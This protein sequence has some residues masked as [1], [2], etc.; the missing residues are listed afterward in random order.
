MSRS[1]K[2]WRRE[3]G[4]HHSAQKPNSPVQRDLMEIDFQW[5]LGSKTRQPNTKSVTL[6]PNQQLTII[7]TD[8][9]EKKMVNLKHN[10]GIQANEPFKNIFVR[11][12]R[13]ECLDQIV[14]VNRVSF[15]GELRHC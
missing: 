12:Q 4:N 8:G 6:S 11:M 14:G 3:R 5:I 10:I 13:E 1:N 15:S 2:N 7:E 9:V